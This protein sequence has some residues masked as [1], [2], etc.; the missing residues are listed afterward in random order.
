[1]L[2]L[3][4]AI[5]QA[6][7]QTGGGVKD[8]LIRE[9]FQNVNGAG[10]ENAGTSPV[11]DYLS[12]FDNPNGWTFSS[13]VYAGPQ[14]I[15]L[16][17]GASV[18]LPAM[19]RLY[20]NA[21]FEFSIDLWEEEAM[22]EENAGEY[23]CRLSISQGELSSDMYELRVA[24]DAYHYIFGGTPESRL[25]VT[26][27]CPVVIR[28]M[29]V[30]YG[31]S[32]EEPTVIFD[33]SHEEGDYFAPI[34]VTFK[35]KTSDE[36]FAD[37]DFSHNI[38]VYTTDGTTPTKQSLRYSGESLH[39]TETTTL[40]PA[41]IRRDGGLSLGHKRTF[42]YPQPAQPQKPNN[43]FEVTVSQPGK[44][45]SQLINIDAD[46]IE[47]LVLKGQINGDDITYLTSGEGRAATITYLDLS[48]MT[49]VLDGTQYH[50]RVEAPEAG[51]GTVYYHYYYLSET[52][53]DEKQPTGGPGSE[54]WNHYRNN[55]AWAFAKCKNLTT[56][57]LP[58]TMTTIGESIFA[59]CSNLKYAPIPDGATEVMESAYNGTAVQ[60]LAG[61]PASINKIGAGAFACL[62]N[63]EDNGLVSF[64]V[65]TIDRPMEIGEGAFA[66]AQVQQ[67]N[68]TSPM[69]SIHA[70]TFACRGL[71]EINIGEGLKFIGEGA[72]SSNVLEKAVLPSSVREICYGAF[73][74]NCPFIKQLT[75]EGGIRYIGKVAYCV[76]DEKLK[77]YTIKDGTI[78]IADQLF[79]YIDISAV[80]LPSSLEIIGNNA[81]NSAAITSLPDM[82][83]LKRIGDG[84]F[85]RS[86]I[87][88]LPSMPKL[89]VIGENAFYATQLT[90]LPE[91][92]SL[93]EIHY[94]AFAYCE[95]LARVT[96]PES[97]EL[98]EHP[99][100]YCD[101]LWSVTYNAI[102]CQC[103][104]GV[105]PR[106]LE[107]IVIGEKVRR[108]PKGLYTG[109]TNIINVTLPKSIEILD[110]EVFA[111]CV[112]LEYVALTDNIT[113]ISDHAFS[114]CSKLTG[115][116]W[117]LHITTIGSDAFR[118]CSALKVVSLPEGVKTVGS[119]AFF[120]CSG[121]ETL[122]MASTIEEAGEGAFSFNNTEKNITIT[123]TA[124]E[125]LD[126]EWNWHYVGKP[127]I[128][129]PAG[130]IEAYRAN[131]VW[132]GSNNMKENTIITIENIEA[133]VKEATTSFTGVEEDV[134]LSDAV[135][136]D[137]YVTIGENDGYDNTDG[138]IV[139]ASSMTSEE[140]E[141][142]GGMA[143]GMTD[144]SNRFNGLVML[145]PAGEGWVN[146]DCQTIGAR[147]VAVKIGEDEPLLFTKD[148]KGA[149]SIDYNVATDTYIY[150]YGV[151]TTPQPSG[152]KRCVKALVSAMTDC[153]KL[154]AITVNPTKPNGVADTEVNF[155]DVPVTHRYTL[156][157][158]QTSASRKQG[159]YIV[160][161]A[162]G[163]AKKIIRR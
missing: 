85:E 120:L 12:K 128:K 110:P 60:M 73:D 43:T 39:I 93:R 47:G 72:F 83:S 36:P 111:N 114:D 149:V 96:L 109:N 107:L 66:G 150:I 2:L 161:R 146:I 31:V 25:T 155:S 106:D 144:L 105:S 7:A 141:A 97:L 29:G 74:K 26:A 87:V 126:Y 55:L 21:Q 68:I 70:S 98:L 37:N 45:K 30:W 125:P 78:S 84:A 131:A 92:P 103:P 32:S 40:F 157:G 163:S 101:A 117:P 64:G 151:D 18:T 76:A 53:Y 65:L 14:C 140:A 50:Y 46:V 104:F 52:N 51:M 75:P 1:M 123:A 13:G 130:S 49:Y 42:N 15:Y 135:V 56:V 129:V 82:P 61:L 23:A 124:T 8:Y 132:N 148:E 134:D 48:E 54:R 159:I 154:Y 90:S 38:I 121:V 100:G 58:R 20:E 153:I 80:H 33:F 71:R 95:K 41:V 108:L 113:T 152:A 81:F 145:V 22:K 10:G 79:G 94:G 99:F 77:E 28:D 147:R 67:L 116:H 119:W 11:Q 158:Q 91:L 19:P 3:S 9:S 112:N 62:Y 88:A 4:T 162:D 142:I 160:R 137:V 138:S 136:G 127:T 24:M 156:G 86:K 5:A 143:P 122:Y 35:Q 102:D 6:F 89:E 59:G 133:S 139:L 16:S 57:I 63:S 69:D 44:L 118:N 34:D 17:K 115:L 27:G